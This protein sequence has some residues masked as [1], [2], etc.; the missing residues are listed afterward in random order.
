[1]RVLEVAVQ[2]TDLETFYPAW[3]NQAMKGIQRDWSFN[4]MRHEADV[5][6][7]QGTTSVPM[8]ADF[9]ELQKARPPIYYR[10]FDASDSRLIPCD[11]VRQEELIRLDTSLLYPARYSRVRPFRYYPVFMD[12]ID[13]QPTLNLLENDHEEMTFLVKYFRYFPEMSRPDDENPITRDYEEMVK[14]KLKAVAF[15]EIGDPQAADWEHVYVLKLKA[16]KDHEAY[17]YVAGR[18]LQM[19]G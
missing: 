1:M 12:W 13:G 14:A 5:T 16:M 17:S 11:I 9:K 3:I 4:A 18:R 7:L 6:I 19:G 8:P 15:E 2:R 10:F